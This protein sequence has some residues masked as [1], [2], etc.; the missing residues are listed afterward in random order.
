VSLEIC[1]KK[2]TCNNNRKNIFF[3]GEMWEEKRNYH[4]LTKQHPDAAG[5]D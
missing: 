1:V 2:K 3:L 4:Y 5:R